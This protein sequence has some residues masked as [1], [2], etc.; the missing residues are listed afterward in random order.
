MKAEKAQLSGQVDVLQETNTELH[1]QLEEFSFQ[2]T[3]HEEDRE[4]GRGQEAHNGTGKQWGVGNA[5]ISRSNDLMEVP[6]MRRRLVQM[7]NE[8]KRTRSK[9][10][11]SQS[12]LKVSSVF[13]DYHCSGMLVWPLAVHSV[14]KQLTQ[15]RAGG[16]KG[17]N[18]AQIT[19]SMSKNH[20]N[21]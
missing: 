10:L 6:R 12:T 14:R 11:N 13:G 2:S 15:G 5:D 1:K 3:C 8:L 4:E 17:R 19:T 18:W 20:H 7:E 9:L 21:T 16:I